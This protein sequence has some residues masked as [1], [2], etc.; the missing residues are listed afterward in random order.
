VEGVTTTNPSIMWAASQ[1]SPVRRVHI[2]S[3]LW[4]SEKGS[5]HWSSGG[6]LADST[7]DGTL[8]FGTQQQF[9]VRNNNLNGG[10]IG[11]SHN[12]VFLG[13]QGAPPSNSA[14]TISTVAATPR[15]SAKPFIT[16]DDGAWS[17]VVPHN[18]VNVVGNNPVRLDTIDFADVFVAKEGDSAATINAGIATK[19]ALLL[20]PGIYGCEVAITIK[21][22]GFVV[23]GMGFATLVALNG[24]SAIHVVASALNVHI[25]S[26]LFEAGTPVTSG[27]TQ[28]LLLWSGDNGVGADIFTRVG[29]FKYSRSFKPSCLKTRADTH[30]EIVGSGVT[31]ENIWAWHADHDD[32]GGSTIASDSCNSQHGLVVQGSNVVVYGLKAE[33]T[34][35]TI[36]QW[37]GEN[38]QVYMFQAELPYHSGGYTSAGAYNVAPNVKQHKGVGHGVYQIATY[39]IDTGFRVPPTADMTNV[40]V[41][42]ITGPV[43]RFRSVMCSSASGMNGCATGD[44]CDYGMCMQYHVWTGAKQPLM[45]AV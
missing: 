24:N 29:A 36:V 14:G 20:T 30:I 28:P 21:K 1:A 26:I 41:W 31:L 19:K 45:I 8:Q 12:Y 22:S 32:C 4:L 37:N 40:F 38:G 10:A 2:K 34:F 3:E 23:L 7:I 42:C 15:V 18:E 35:D 43:S 6:L 11:E 39:T 25:A 5:P 17:I 27:P 9:L 33:H 44:H 13:S 16:E